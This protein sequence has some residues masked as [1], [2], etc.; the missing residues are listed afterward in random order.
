M[1]LV[2]FESGSGA[3][4]GARGVADAVLATGWILGVIESGAAGSFGVRRQSGPGR[5]AFYGYSSLRQFPPG[6]R[7]V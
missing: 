3:G 6:A 4:A 2:S 1:A 7:M 5:H